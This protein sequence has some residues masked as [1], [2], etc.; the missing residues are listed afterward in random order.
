M[1]KF[2]VRHGSFPCTMLSHLEYFDR[3]SNWWIIEQE[4]HEWELAPEAPADDAWT[5]EVPEP[6]HQEVL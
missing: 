2:M 4:E 1:Y 6:P 3:L 5:E